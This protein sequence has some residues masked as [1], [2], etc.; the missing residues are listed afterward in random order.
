MESSKVVMDERANGNGVNEPKTLTSS[1][2]ESATGAVGGFGSEVLGIEEM[3]ANIR[4]LGSGC[5]TEREMSEWNDIR[6]RVDLLVHGAMGS[7]QPDSLPT[8]E[9]KKILTPHENMV[10]KGAIPKDKNKSTN[11]SKEVSSEKESRTGGSMSGTSGGTSRRRVRRR[12]SEIEKK[13]K[14]KLKNKSSESDDETTVSSKTETTVKTISTAKTTIPV[15]PVTENEK[16]LVECLAQVIGATKEIPEP[17]AFEIHTTRKWEEFL[18]QF[19]KYCRAR[20]SDD[21]EYWLQVLE[22]YLEGEVKTMYLCFQGEGRKYD[23]LIKKLSR[24]VKGRVNQ[25]EIDFIGAFHEAVMKNGETCYMYAGR[26]EDLA[27]KA[28]PGDK[29]TAHQ[30]L[31]RKFLLTIPKGPLSEQIRYHDALNQRMTGEKMGWKDI[32]ELILLESENENQNMVSSNQGVNSQPAG[33]LLA[34]SPVLTQ[35]NETVKQDKKKKKKSKTK[36]K[37][38][39]NTNPQPTPPQ[40]ESFQTQAAWPPNQQRSNSQPSRNMAP[41]PTP[42]S[43]NR[44]DSSPGNVGASGSTSGN[45]GTTTC[46]YCGKGGHQEDTCWSKSAV[47]YICG[48]QN[49]LARYCLRKS[50]FQNRGRGRGRGRGGYNNYGN[51]PEFSA[52]T[53][54]NQMNNYNAN[55]SGYPADSNVTSPPPVQSNAQPQQPSNQSF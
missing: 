10:G 37:N 12:R 5:K 20:Y 29:K 9:S 50:A 7:T 15:T 13:Y 4:L 41:T 19:E 53:G 11:K 24:W 42:N 8:P 48:G 35:S 52:N 33:C 25:I 21:K 55:N 17:K 14:R 31:R 23:K 2:G 3:L 39:V 47:C 43:V 38:T 49:H 54:S 34:A 40:P 45:P 30:Q 1:A 28:Y 27:N 16:S 26:L 51:R 22:K 18:T 36:A 44:Q 46:T 6:K 32:R